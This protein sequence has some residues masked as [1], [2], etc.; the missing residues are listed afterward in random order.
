VNASSTKPLPTEKALRD[1]GMAALG[2]FKDSD[3]EDV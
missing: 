2:S 1:Q 3:K